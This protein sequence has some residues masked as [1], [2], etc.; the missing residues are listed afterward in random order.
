[1]TDTDALREAIA[2]AGLK[3]KFVAASL[4]LTPFGLKK[5]IDNRTEFKASEISAL[6]DILSLTDRQVMSIFFKKESDF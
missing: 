5:K 4:G 6:A 3:Y 1:M 2:A